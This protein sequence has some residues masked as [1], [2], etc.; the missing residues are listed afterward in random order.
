MSIW[1]R[2]SEAIAALISAGES[3]IAFF[4]RPRPPETSVAFT[5]A[6]VALGAKMAKADGQVR[7]AE[8]TA[9]RQVFQIA[10]RDEAA[11]AR[12]FNLARQDVAGFEAYAGQIARMFRH[13]PAMLEDV[14][15]GLFHIAMADGR[16]HDGEEDFLRRVAEIFALPSR[17]FDLIEAR[18]LRDRAEDPWQVLGIP[19]DSDLATARARWRMLVQAH[20]PD[21]LIARG[22]PPETVT[23]AND[24]LAAIN[25]AWEEISARLAPQRPLIPDQP[26]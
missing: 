3:L 11:A 13:D 4:D 18:H 15:E 2:I 8:V 6:V 1:T 23:L 26:A 16:Y 9:F 19:R 20:H 21:K 24:R 7:P 25:A 22:L 17:T 5:I 10:P 12:V 14:L